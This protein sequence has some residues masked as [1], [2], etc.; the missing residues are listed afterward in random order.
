MPRRTRLVENYCGRRIVEQWL[1]SRTLDQGV[2]KHDTGYWTDG[3]SG[4]PRKK[5]Q[6]VREWIDQQEQA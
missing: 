2:T 6:E 5:I 4:F 1:E 3:M